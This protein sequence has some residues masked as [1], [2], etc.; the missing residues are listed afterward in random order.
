MEGLEKRKSRNAFSEVRLE[1]E[2]TDIP[3]HVLPRGEKGEHLVLPTNARLLVQ[4]EGLRVEMIL[5]EPDDEYW[6]DFDYENPPIVFLHLDK[7]EILRLIVGGRLYGRGSH[8]TAILVISDPGDVV[9]SLTLTFAST[10]PNNPEYWT[11]ALAK[12]LR[13]R[14]G[15]EIEAVVEEPDDES[16]IPF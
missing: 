11:K 12:M 9:D 15:V 7:E 5:R 2:K 13:E 14:L 4:H 10:D 1:L 16:Y 6:P 3:R 8:P